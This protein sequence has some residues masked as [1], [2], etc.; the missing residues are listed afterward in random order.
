MGNIFGVQKYGSSENVKFPV[1][2]TP[3][4]AGYDL[5]SINKMV[6]PA[7]QSKLVPTGLSFL[8]PENHFLFI[9]NCSSNS[10][11]GLVV[12]AGVVDS[13]Y[14]GQIFVQLFNFSSTDYILE[15]NSKIAQAICIPIF[16]KGLTRLDPYNSFPLVTDRQN[17]GFGV[18]NTNV[19][20]P[21]EHYMNST[22]QPSTPNQ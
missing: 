9:T 21:P 13:D 8:I 12:G 15:T 10:L 6:V 11:K 22:T 20:N 2:K 5:F 19:L 18:P 1:R 3:F 17:A 16:E 14:T 4:S 7:G